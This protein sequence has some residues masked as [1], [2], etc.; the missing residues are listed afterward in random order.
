[1]IL[2]IPLSMLLS[3]SWPKEGEVG[4]TSHG[5]LSFCHHFPI[6]TDS[7]I[8]IVLFSNIRQ[9]GSWGDNSVPLTQD[10]NDHI[11]RNIYSSFFFLMLTCK[12]KFLFPLWE[13]CRSYGRSGARYKFCIIYFHCLV[14]FITISSIV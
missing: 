1:M 8:V 2:D 3:V 7:V 6:Y 11:T 5:V 14:P 9:K 4:V 12:G 10:K 13:Y